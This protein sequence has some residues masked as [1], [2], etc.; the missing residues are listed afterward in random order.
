M[1]W[2]FPPHSVDY[3]ATPPK[4]W[5]ILRPV[6]VT[7]FQARPKS[8]SSRELQQLACLNDCARVWGYRAHPDTQ[9]H[10]AYEKQTQAGA[11]SIQPFTDILFRA[12]TSSYVK[13]D[14]DRTV[15]AKWMAFGDTLAVAD[16]LAWSAYYRLFVQEPDVRAALLAVSRDSHMM[17]TTAIC[18][19]CAARF[20]LG[21]AECPDPRVVE[22]F[23]YSVYNAMLLEQP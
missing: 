2:L 22:N 1:D 8:L 10:V 17:S 4:E 15:A 21:C 13:R 5:E 3:V 14:Y 6:P 11:T 9:E 20:V 16:A 23:A 7:H 19:A 12:Q 18:V